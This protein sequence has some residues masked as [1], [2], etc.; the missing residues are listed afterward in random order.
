MKGSASPRPMPSK[1]PVSPSISCTPSRSRMKLSGGPRLLVLLAVWAALVGM[2]A[3][4]GVKR[5]VIVKI[6]GLP[7][8]YVD[9]FVRQRDPETGKSVLPW[10]EEVFYKNGSHLEN[11]YTRGMSLS[12]PS[13]GLLD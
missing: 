11:F 10:I 4:Q 7:G 5:V 8:Y 3:G 1:L 2:A 12:G 13:W 9:R 6:D